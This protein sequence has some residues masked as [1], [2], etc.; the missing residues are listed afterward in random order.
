ME[1]FYLT[2]LIICFSLIHFT[3]SIV[4]VR[5]LSECYPNCNEC[6]EL[7]TDPHNMQCL[8]C[9]EGFNLYSKSHN[10]LNCPHYIN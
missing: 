2:L 4:K 10:C 3:Q 8:S 7:S 9:K 5:I 6:L 1:K